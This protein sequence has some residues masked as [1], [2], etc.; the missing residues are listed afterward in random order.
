MNKELL[1]QWYGY[2]ERIIFC[3]FVKDGNLYC[4]FFGELLKKK[5][6]EVGFSGN[7]LIEL[8]GVYGKVNYGGV[9]FNWE[10]GRNIL[11]CE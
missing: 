7:K 11:S 1:C 3:E 5:R 6:I 9:V 10:I 8:I 2:L 4:F